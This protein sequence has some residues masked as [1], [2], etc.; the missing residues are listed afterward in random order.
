[1]KETGQAVF[2]GCRRG[3]RAGVEPAGMRDPVGTMADVDAGYKA[4]CAKRGL[5]SGNWMARRDRGL[6]RLEGKR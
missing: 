3:F 4:F 1:M 5:S 6:A 2:R